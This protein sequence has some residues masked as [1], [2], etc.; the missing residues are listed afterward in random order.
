MVVAIPI[1]SSFEKGKCAKRLEYYLEVNRVEEEDK[2]ILEKKYCPFYDDGRCRI[3]HGLIG[4]YMI[5]Y[6]QK[7]TYEKTGSGLV[8]IEK[9]WGCDVISL[10]YK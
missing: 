6:P 9:P 5:G 2:M 4:L 8:E 1:C 10:R 3:K 7:H